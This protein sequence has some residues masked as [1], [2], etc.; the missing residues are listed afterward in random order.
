MQP[1][2]EQKQA[3]DATGKTVLVVAGAGSGK[4]Q[5]LAWRIN[6]DIANGINPS[7]I[8]C[9]TFTVAG[10][11][12]MRQRLARICPHAQHIGFIG[13]LHSYAIAT[14]ARA[15]A[16]LGY[17]S[18]DLTVLD[19]EAADALLETIREKFKIK[20]PLGEIKEW[21]G[22]INASRPASIAAAHYLKDMRQR[23]AVDFS[24]A[25]HDMV[26]LLEAGAV[27]PVESLYVDEYQ[28][29][30][31]IDAKIYDL[32]E[33]KRK[34]FVGDPD[35]AIYGFRGA[36]MDNI[37]ELA[38]DPDVHVCY[39][40][41]NYRSG[42]HIINAAAKTIRHNTRRLDKTMRCTTEEES[43]VR[44]LDLVN[45]AEEVRMIANT[46]LKPG[47]CR[48]DFAVLT[49]YNERANAI[50]TELQKYGVMVQR[51]RTEHK[52]KKE[53]NIAIGAL[54]ALH[55]PKDDAASATW[56]N[57]TIIT[58]HSRIAAL[59]SANGTSIT[60]ELM[61]QL[62]V[63]DTDQIGVALHAMK[64]P[65]LGID[66]ICDAWTGDAATT[67]AALRDTLEAESMEGEGVFVGTLHSA[68]GREWKTVFLA[69]TEQSAIPAKKTGEELEAE[70]RLF[71]VGITRARRELIITSCANVLDT[72]KN[73]VLA[74]HPS[75]FISEAL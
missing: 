64:V 12:E 71:Y 27:A 70:R 2:E 29:S 11:K 30:A 75:T 1:N 47:S 46:V 73:K 4:T 51:P 38:A 67:A 31:A 55:N 63:A 13:T 69:G 59:A 20:A 40:Q 57:A 18:A 42:K 17:K 74:T 50:A 3:I 60:K 65:K 33:A 34:F 45:E 72:W 56:R 62:K 35:Q 39:L 49:R 68:K 15:G 28:D 61:K 36:R 23:N 8:V 14:I 22:Q 25:L 44:R 52:G 26:R 32:I 16:M 21:V 53:I 58:G 41:S 9:I 7:G 24:T 6:S 19:E 66:A 5:T 10:A 54:N 37:L 48:Q 43:T